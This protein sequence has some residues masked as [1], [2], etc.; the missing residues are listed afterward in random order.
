TEAALVGQV[1]SEATLRA[2]QAAL[3]QD[4]QPLTDLRASASYRLRTA[5]NL[6]ERFWLETRTD[7]PLPASAVQVWPATC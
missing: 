1:W 7:A 3:A 4:F 2:A 5:R 6:L